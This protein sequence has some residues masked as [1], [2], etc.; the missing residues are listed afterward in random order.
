MKHRGQRIRRLVQPSVFIRVDS[1]LFAVQYSLVLEVKQKC[2]IAVRS[3]INT[4]P[5]VRPRQQSGM[6]EQKGNREWTRSYANETQGTTHPATRAA[7]VFIRGL[8]QPR[9]GARIAHFN[10]GGKSSSG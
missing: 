6:E 3:K 5:S 10:P 2:R 8:I 9:A 4:P 1:R 7:S